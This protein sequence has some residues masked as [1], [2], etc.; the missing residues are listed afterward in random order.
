MIHSKAH[1]RESFLMIK[2]VIPRARETVL[3]LKHFLH[4]QWDPSLKTHIKSWSQQ[5]EPVSPALGGRN[6][7]MLGGACWLAILADLEG[8]GFHGRARLT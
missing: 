4:K 5:H 8:L 7:R 2:N 1:A 6:A 3:L